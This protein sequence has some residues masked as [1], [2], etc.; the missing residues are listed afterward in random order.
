ME[1]RNVGRSGLRVS[2]VGPRLQQLRRPHRPRR[3]Q[4]VVHRAL[5]AGITLFDTADIYGNRGGSERFLGELLGDRRK[6]IVLATK[7]GMAMDDAGVLQRRLA[8]LHHVGGRGEPQA[9]AHRLD[10]PLPAAPARPADADRGDAARARRPR[11][12]RARCAT[13][14]APTCRHGRSPTPRGRRAI[15][16]SP[17]FVS[18]QDEYSLLARARTSSSSCRRCERSAWACCPI[19]RSRAACSPASTGATRRCRKARGLTYTKPAAERFL[20]E[21]NWTRVRGACAAS[22]EHA[23]TR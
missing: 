18:A 7:F 10:R 8:P 11:A 2:L 19:T 21:R 20:T 17:R 16:A 1:F 5:D 22:R 9:P 15:T 23:A 13:S 6:D 4:R 12:R 3:D 14:A